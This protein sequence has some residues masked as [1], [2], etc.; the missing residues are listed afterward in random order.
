ML[1]TAVALLRWTGSGATALIA[2]ISF[3][4]VGENILS[5]ASHTPLTSMGV[6]L[7][8][9]SSASTGTETFD[10]NGLIFTGNFKETTVNGANGTFTFTRT[11][12]SGPLSGKARHFSGAYSGAGCGVHTRFIS[13]DSGIFLHCTGDAQ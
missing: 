10:S 13:T 6:D 3:Q 5:T 7:F 11:Y 1:S 8:T 9:T 12:T 4:C 2:K